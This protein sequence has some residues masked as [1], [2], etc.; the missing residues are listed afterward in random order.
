MR[1]LLDTNVLAIGMAEHAWALD[2]PSALIWQR[3]K[4]KEFDILVSEHL[5]DEVERTL[6]TKWFEKRSNPGTL[7]RAR[8]RLRNEAILVEV[9]HEV[10][11]VASHWQDDLVLAAAVSGNADYLVTRDKEFRK[12]E[13]H[14]GV[15]IRTPT[16][17]LIQL[18]AIQRSN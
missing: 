6:S 18:E 5:L 11:G 3:W 17:F 7:L 14:H 15:R 1:V 4:A 16:E 12:V 8:F 9:T 10:H 13:E 2:Q